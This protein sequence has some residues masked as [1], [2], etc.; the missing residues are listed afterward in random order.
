MQVLTA[1]TIQ[2]EGR[3]ESKMLMW[4]LFAGS[5]GGVNRIRIISLLR[6]RPMNR[7]QIST[8][9]KIDYKAVRHH[10]E[11]LEKNNLI[12]NLM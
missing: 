1:R 9:L 2:S 3:P 10:T 12:E 11:I 7:H 5:R 6:Q 4:Y 8:D